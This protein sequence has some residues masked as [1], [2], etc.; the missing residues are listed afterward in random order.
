MINHYN[1]F[2]FMHLLSGNLTSNTVGICIWVLDVK[3]PLK[4][5]RL[6]LN[7]RLTSTTPMGASGHLTVLKRQL[8]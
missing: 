7:E 5:C 4:R 3:L 2:L 6:K 1:E 8:V